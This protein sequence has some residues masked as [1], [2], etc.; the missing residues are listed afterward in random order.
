MNSSSRAPIPYVNLPQTARPNYIQPNHLSQSVSLVPP[1]NQQIGPRHP[2]NVPPPNVLSP[3]TTIGLPNLHQSRPR[4]PSTSNAPKGPQNSLA[5][6]FNSNLTPVQP[7][8]QPR[9]SSVSS[10]HLSQDDA[11]TTD[12]EPVSVKYNV[13]KMITN[14]FSNKANQYLILITRIIYFFRRE[15]LHDNRKHVNNAQKLFQI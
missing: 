11:S 5:P 14:D 7:P 10:S 8:D 9:S 12:S 6:T 15:C 13:G 4:L 1:P 2:N 3:S